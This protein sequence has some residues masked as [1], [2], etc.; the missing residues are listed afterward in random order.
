MLRRRHE[1]GRRRTTGSAPAGHQSTSDTEEACCAASR[2]WAADNRA[3]KP[4]L[5]VRG[6]TRI[7]EA[8]RGGRDRSNKTRTG[9][10]QS[11]ERADSDVIIVAAAKDAIS[12]PGATKAATH[13]EQQAARQISR[14]RQPRA[15]SPGLFKWP[16]YS[17]TAFSP[18]IIQVFLPFWALPNQKPTKACPVAKKAAEISAPPTHRSRTQ[19]CRLS[20]PSHAP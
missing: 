1:R 13:L 4:L 18:E 17:Q 6:P 2:Q 5:P 19:L 3:G 10:D 9:Y 11:A 14:A 12:R 16:A 7:V 8:G 15:R 20:S